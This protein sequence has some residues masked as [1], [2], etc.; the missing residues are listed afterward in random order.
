[1]PFLTARDGRATLRLGSN[2]L[3][4]RGKDAVDLGALASLP[5]TAVLVVR[6]DA[7]SVIRRLAPQTLIRVDGHSLGA[8]P[9]ELRHGTRIDI[10]NHQLTY[11]HPAPLRAGP[12]A[13]PSAVGTEML[14]SVTVE[15]SHFRLVESKTGL[16]VE[17]PESGATLGRERGCDIVVAGEGV[18][19]RHATIEPAGEGFMLTDQSSN[20]TQVNGT[21]LTGPHSLR[22][23][24][25]IMIGVTAFRWE[26]KAKERPRPIPKPGDATEL[27]SSVQSRRPPVAE[28][29]AP[30][31]ARP[32]PAESFAA[33]P[34]LA[35]LSN[36]SLWRKEFRIERPVA[37]IG[38]G[39]QN[40]VRIAHESVSASHA[41]LVRKGETW[42]VLDLGSSNGTFVDGLR[43]AG[44][45]EL[46]A[47]STLTLGT[48]KLKFQPSIAKIGQGGTQHVGRGELLRR[49][50]SLWEKG[51]SRH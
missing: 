3:G 1:M 26:T 44:E 35:T 46:P 49:L 32:V 14:P 22:S 4:G 31:S 19:R 45:R 51:S 25:V 7:L 39:D 5:A 15:K 27:V 16:V 41:T 13:D 23:G 17:I 9:A 47:G 29:S 37:S 18:S 48:V 10:G 30:E 6:P 36:R 21:K 8:E 43:V 33:T 38:R 28:V 34:V 40:D 24:D 11:G 20:G 12:G 50:A 42:F 2:V